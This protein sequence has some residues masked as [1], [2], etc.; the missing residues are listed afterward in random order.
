MQVELKFSDTNSFTI[1]EVIAQA[2]RNYGQGVSVKIM[3][4]SMRPTDL[5]EFAISNFITAEQVSYYFDDQFTYASKM[6]KLKADIMYRFSESI[7]SVIKENERKI[8]GD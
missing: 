1:E 2:K 7:D 5:L 8:L 6:K 4:E 3:P